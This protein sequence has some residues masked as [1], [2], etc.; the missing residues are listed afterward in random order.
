MPAI[1]RSSALG[2]RLKGSKIFSI[3]CGRQPDA[4]ILHFEQHAARLG[5]DANANVRPVRRVL[6]G[7]VEQVDQHLLDPLRIGKHRARR[8]DDVE[9]QQSLAVQLLL[10]A[11]DDVA[12][13]IGRVDRPQ[14]HAAACPR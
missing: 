4:A 3:V 12:H 14:A 8:A 13:E 10:V 9:R 1:W 7:V 6:H 5:L 2:A 11:A